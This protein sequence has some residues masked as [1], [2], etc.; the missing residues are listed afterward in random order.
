MDSPPG[1]LQ[2]IACSIPNHSKTFAKILHSLC[3]SSHFTEEETYSSQGHMV[4]IPVSFY[5]V[6][7]HPPNQWLR[8]T[9]CLAHSP[10]DW[11]GCWE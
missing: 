10:R 2:S 11:L 8:I 3:S 7:N 5:F 6:T 4:G 9:I 1:G